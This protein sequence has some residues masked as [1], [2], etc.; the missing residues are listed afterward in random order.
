MYDIK[1]LEANKK[2]NSPKP[3]VIIIT[4]PTASGKTAVALSLAKSLP[5]E[6]VSVDSALIYRGM[7][8]GTAKPTCLE[9]SIA[10][11]HLIDILEPTEIYSAAQFR[12]DAISCIDDIISRN[13]LPVLVGGSMLYFKILLNGI[14]QLPEAN[15]DI[16]KQLNNI[17]NEKGWDFLHRQLCSIDQESALRI[18]VTDTQRLQRA[19][20]VYKLTKKPL[21][22]WHKQQKL[23]SLPYNMLTFAIMPNNREQLHHKI[24]CRFYH[25][26]ENGFIDEAK[27][28][29]ENPGMDISLPSMRAVGYRQ[30]WEYLTNKT[31]KQQSFDKAI[32]ATR[33]LAKRQITWLRS[34]KN[35]NVIDNIDEK[36]NGVIQTSIKEYLA[37]HHSML[38]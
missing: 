35:C 20:E 36:N 37:K 12:Q 22:V 26:I 38:A 31:T 8:I 1:A 9:Q 5:I 2:T 28:L 21:S 29:F 13:K 18:K 3:P 17:A 11:H 24:K 14:A 10:P 32:A 19:L 16:R 30:I 27:K 25:M 23:Q 6:I 7:D 33:Q 34:W 4:G 15:S